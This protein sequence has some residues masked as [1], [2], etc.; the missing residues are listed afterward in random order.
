[1]TNNDTEER[2]SV[3]SS[4]ELDLMLR[5]ADFY[6]ARFDGRREFEWKVTLGLWGSVLGGIVALREF[7]GKL[8]LWPLVVLA[9]LVLFGHYYWLWSVWR[10][11]RFDKDA[12]F[13]FVRRV[14]VILRVEPPAFGRK[15][16][17]SIPPAM[18][19]QLFV[20]AVLLIGAVAFFS[21]P[22]IAG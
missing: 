11:H 9:L 18:A 22:S 6:I 13:T 15:D 1:M 12:A 14:A 8:P 17:L 20:T 7:S 19:F 16:F 5:L 4:E 2:R 10:A 3:P 21:L